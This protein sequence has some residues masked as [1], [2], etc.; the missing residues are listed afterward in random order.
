MSGFQIP[1][2]YVHTKWSTIQNPD[3]FLQNRLQKVRISNGLAQTV[4]YIKIYMY[5]CRLM[6]HS[7]SGHHL[8]SGQ[9]QPFAIRTRPNFGSPLH[10]ALILQRLGKVLIQRT[11]HPNTGVHQDSRV[12]ANGSIIRKQEIKN[13]WLSNVSGSVMSDIQ[14]PTVTYTL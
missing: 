11:P 2:V 8:K 6:Y 5:V 12:Q 3:F 10:F 13:V 14:N 1:T 9:G 7:K 4:F